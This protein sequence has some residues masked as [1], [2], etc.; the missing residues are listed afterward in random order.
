MA[1]E[2]RPSSGSLFRNKD[3]RPDR[4][5]PDLTGRIMLPDGTVH[6]FKAWSKAT[7]AGEKWLSC[8]IGEPVQ[9]AG[10]PAASTVPPLDA[11]NQAK[12]NGF[13]PDD[14]DIPF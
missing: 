12:G 5:D 10:R 1:Y 8:Q 14:D 9:G 4:K 6:W 2:M 13:Q 7:G 3:K 11:H